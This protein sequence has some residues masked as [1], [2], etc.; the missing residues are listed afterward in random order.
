VFK[1]ELKRDPRLGRFRVL[2][3]NA[4]Y[5]LWHYLG[6]ANGVNL[7]LTAYQYLVYG[8]RPAEARRYR[9]T[10]RWIYLRQDWLAYRELACAGK[11]RF[12]GWLLSLAVAPKVCQLFAW[13][14]PLPFLNRLQRVVKSRLPRLTAVLRR[15]LSTA[16]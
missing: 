6:A 1:I 14:D 11:L 8:K 3:V 15:W 7:P 5:N 9:T 16:S 2:E 12:A 10:R 13:S 4:R